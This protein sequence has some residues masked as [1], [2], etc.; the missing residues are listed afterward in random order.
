MDA[1]RTLWTVG[2]STH[3]WQTF[4]D[5]L[6]GAGIRL[7]ADVRL[8]PGSR[9]HPQFDSDAMA[10][11]LPLAGIGYTHLRALGGRRRPRKD[12]QNTAWRHQAFRGYA[13]YM[14]TADFQR[15]RGQL[16]ELAAAT[17]TAVMCAEALWWQCHRSLISDDF[18][19]D[20]WTVLHLQS[21]GGATEHPYSGAARI[22]DGRLDYSV[23]EDPQPGLF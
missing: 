17:P 21:K 8:L 16:A 9:R 6:T 20:G 2:H 13:D 18:K 19:A 11:A 7:I 12:S 5:L 14:E 10:A 4:V 15:A 23:P 3:P 22:V 1:P